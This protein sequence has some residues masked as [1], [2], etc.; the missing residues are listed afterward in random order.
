MDSPK[1]FKIYIRNI[2][3]SED[4]EKNRD[5]VYRLNLSN[6]SANFVTVAVVCFAD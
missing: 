2:R 1:L 3:S 6:K 5:S 4:L